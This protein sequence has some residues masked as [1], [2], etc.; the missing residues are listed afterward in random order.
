MFHSI[1]QSWWRSLVALMFLGVVVNSEDS[2]SLALDDSFDQD[3]VVKKVADDD[4][5]ESAKGKENDDDDRRDKKSIKGKDDDDGAG[6]KGESLDQLRA[7]LKQLEAENAKL[8]SAFQEK[9][10]AG[11]KKIPAGKGDDKLPPKKSGKFTESQPQK[12]GEKQADEQN[13]ILIKLKKIQGQVEQLQKEG[14]KEEAEKLSH[15][16]QE[17]EQMLAQRQTKHG[18]ETKHE[19]PAI[20]ERIEQLKQEIEESTR[21]GKKDHVVALRQ[22]LEKTIDHV[23]QLQ[24]KGFAKPDPKSGQEAPHELSAVIKQLSEQVHQLRAE[25]EELRRAVKDRSDD[26]KK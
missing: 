22:E 11:G 7:R 19:A 5:K 4:D 6:E 23:Q 26:R 2:V 17:L 1:R 20:A 10:S 15:A 24:K 16:A 12:G 9:E 14:R 25:V 18:K 8:R 21:A 3:A 13:E